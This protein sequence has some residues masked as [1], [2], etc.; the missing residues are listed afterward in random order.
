M[1][2]VEG[3]GEKP[4][5][6]QPKHEMELL[7]GAQPL[8]FS[9]RRDVQRGRDD[10]RA[11]PDQEGGNTGMG[12]YTRWQKGFPSMGVQKCIRMQ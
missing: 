8:R 3:R 10:R 7:D 9:S 2:G 6:L 5:E 4:S 1:D 12:K 11:R